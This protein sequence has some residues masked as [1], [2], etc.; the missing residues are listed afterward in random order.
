MQP[1]MLISQFISLSDALR[2]EYAWIDAPNPA[3]PLIVFLHEG[4]GSL[5][6]WRDFP[7]RLCKAAGARGLVYSR[8]GYGQSTPRKADEHWPADFLQHQAEEVLPALLDALHVAEPVYLFGHSDGG[9]IA[10]LFAAKYP[11]RTRGLVVL[12]PHLDVEQEAIDSI[13]SARE[14]YESTDLRARLARYHADVDSAFYGWNDVWLSAAFR[15]FNIRDRLAAI[16][17]PILAVQGEEDEYGTL[18]Q[19]MQIKDHQAQTQLLV[20]PHCGHSAHRDCPDKVIAASC[21]FIE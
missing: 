5:A 12:A 6:M 9:S 19:I 17:C 20:L 18:A 11:Q 4:L 21:E 8:A 1:I 13:K 10:L 7:A 3:A 16:Q 14:T 15:S 2:L